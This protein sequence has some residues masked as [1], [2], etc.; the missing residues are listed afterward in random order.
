MEQ[1]IKIIIT[2]FTIISALK[3]RLIKEKSVLAP[4][5]T[6]CDVIS[7]S[8]INSSHLNVS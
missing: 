8:I 7:A 5:P 1:T 4:N 2:D 6:A 3:N